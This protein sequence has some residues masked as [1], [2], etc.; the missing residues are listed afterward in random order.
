MFVEKKFLVLVCEDFGLIGI[1]CDS[2]QEIKFNYGKCGRHVAKKKIQGPCS[3]LK[4]IQISKTQKSEF[5]EKKELKTANKTS[6]DVDVLL[7]DTSCEW[8][9]RHVCG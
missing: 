4:R 8:L 6:T 3:K 9:I 7:H 2:I 1:N 5:K